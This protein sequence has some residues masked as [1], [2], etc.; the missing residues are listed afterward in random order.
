MDKG[1]LDGAIARVYRM[2]GGVI[3]ISETSRRRVS[4]IE[5]SGSS[6]RSIPPTNVS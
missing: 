1:K 5:Y 3:D 2:L 4:L 6:E